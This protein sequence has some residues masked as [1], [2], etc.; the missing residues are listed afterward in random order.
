MFFY[1][2][3]LVGKDDLLIDSDLARQILDLYCDIVMLQTFDPTAARNE[4]E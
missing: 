2:E 1:V 4:D 3:T